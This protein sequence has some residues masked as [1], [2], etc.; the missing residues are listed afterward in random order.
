MEACEVSVPK[1]PSLRSAFIKRLS[2]EHH[3]SSPNICFVSPSSS[4]FRMIKHKAVT[5]H[6]DSNLN[7]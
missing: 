5:C 1:R 7:F 3:L 2:S 6:A 4:P